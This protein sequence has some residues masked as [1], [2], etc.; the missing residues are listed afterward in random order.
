[1][2][3]IGY[4]DSPYVRRVAIS[5]DLMGIP[6]EHRELSIFRDFDEFRAINPLVK[7]PTLVLDDGT[8]LVESGLIID[9]LEGLAPCERRLLPTAPDDLLSARRLLGITLVAMEKA[10]SLIYERHQRPAETQHQPWID[11]VFTQLGGA[12]ELLEL[13]LEGVDGWLFG[14]RM[15]QADITLAVA[16]RFIQAK[17]PEEVPAADYPRLTGFSARAEALEDFARYSF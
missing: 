7:V 2:Q 17:W 15:L 9:H 3:L 8:V 6:F 11:R 16:W 10:V 14:E 13:K 5:A 4:L 1:M 12:C